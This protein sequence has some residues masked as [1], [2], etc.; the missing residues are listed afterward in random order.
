[1][2]VDQLSSSDDQTYNGVLEDAPFYL[3]TICNRL[4]LER[5]H[6]SLMS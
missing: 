4:L 1:M 2:T 3:A 5:W 6:R